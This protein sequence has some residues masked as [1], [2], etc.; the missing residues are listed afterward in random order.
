MRFL[1]NFASDKGY[2]STLDIVRVYD[3]FKKP[4]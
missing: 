2:F 4:S 1:V 3:K